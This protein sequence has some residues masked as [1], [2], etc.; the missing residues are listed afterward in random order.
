M[1]KNGWGLLNPKQDKYLEW[2]LPDAESPEAR[3]EIAKEHIEKS[4]RQ[5]QHFHAA[6]DVPA[7]APDSVKI[8]LFAGD[9]L[10]TPKVLQAREFGKGFKVIEVDHG[11]GTVLRSSALMDERVGGEW[12]PYLPTPIDFD[13]II[14]LFN[15]HTGLTKDPIFTDN[16]L[17]RLLNQPR[18]SK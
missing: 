13:E 10:M 9:A 3:K 14:F 16:L 7:K 17:H 11:D 5:A 15:S 1:G 4:L 18:L 12:V 6:L 2:L 8:T